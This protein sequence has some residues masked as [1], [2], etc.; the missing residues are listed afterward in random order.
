MS[1]VVVKTIRCIIAFLIVCVVY[2][3]T[4]Y[5]VYN[6]SQELA[7]ITQFKIFLCLSSVVSFFASILFLK[8]FKQALAAFAV[9]M[10]FS[11]CLYIGLF[12]F[13]IYLDMF[14]IGPFD[15]FLPWFFVL[16]IVSLPYT[17]VN[18]F[19]NWFAALFHHK[20]TGVVKQQIDS[21]ERKK[22]C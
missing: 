3:L 4:W 21:H 7:I 13:A 19:G 17:I 15:M 10:I 6:H 9:S 18:S 22:N 11:Y 8:W 5:L 20:F 16:I 1:I 12:F 2:F 14:D